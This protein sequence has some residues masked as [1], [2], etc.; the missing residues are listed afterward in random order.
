MAKLYERVRNWFAVRAAKRADLRKR[1]K[2]LAEQGFLV[3]CRKCHHDLN[4]VDVVPTVTEDET[5]AYTC[6]DC[7][8]VSTFLMD[9]PVPLC[10]ETH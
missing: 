6:P 1:A 5:Y 10:L 7:G 9:A 3:Y 4:A 2:V 8:T